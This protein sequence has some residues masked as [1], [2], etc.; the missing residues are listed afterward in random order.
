MCLL[1]T[2]TG[3]SGCI[4]G[5]RVYTGVS[6]HLPSATFS[7]ALLL[8]GER[9]ATGLDVTQFLIHISE[10]ALQF[11]LPLI[12]KSVGKSQFKKHIEL[13]LEPL[14]YSI[15]CGN[16]LAAVPA[17]KCALFISTFIGLV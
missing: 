15:S 11:Q 13:F 2:G 8:A 16:N 3:S 7:D 12:A 4:R 17:R 5:S 6:G 14:Q 1:T 10:F 9:L